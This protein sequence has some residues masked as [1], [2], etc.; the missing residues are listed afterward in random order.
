MKRFTLILSLL[1]ILMIA[2][3]V[4]QA[5]TI[6]CSANDAYQSSLGKMIAKADYRDTIAD[7]YEMKGE[8]I[9]LLSNQQFEAYGA[10]MKAFT[11]DLKKMTNV[12]PSM[13]P[14]HEAM[15]GLFGAFG[16]FLSDAADVGVLRAAMIHEEE[17]TSATDEFNRQ[18]AKLPT[19]CG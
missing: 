14:Y 13:E 4:A 7:F 17:I 8:D 16:I 1:A 18:L 2:P 19:N 6:S 10:D 3:S 5:A 11:R 15:I 12:D 9:F